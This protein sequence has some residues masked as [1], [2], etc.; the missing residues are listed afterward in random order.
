MKK[1]LAV[2]FFLGSAAD[3]LAQDTTRLSLLFLGDIMQHDSQISDAWDPTMKSY[4]YFPCFKQ[5]KPYT[6]AADLTI[7]NLELT[8]AGPPYKGYPQFSAPDE[9]LVALKD[10]GIDV[11]VTAN[12]HCVDRGKQGLERTVALLDSFNIPHTGTF[13]DDVSKLN[14]H[15]LLI[16]RNNFNLAILNYT[17]GTN[18]MPVTEPNIVN[19]IDTA[20]IRID[21]HKA[22][23][24]KQDVVIVFVHWG[25]EYQSLPSEWQEIV[26]DHCFKNGA[27]LVIGAHPHVIQPMEWDKNKNQLIAYSLG[28]FVSGQRKRYTDGGAMIN[29]ELEKVSYAS[30]SSKTRIDTANYI[31]QWVYRTEIG[32]N[33][34]MLPVQKFEKDTTFIADQESRD[35]FK[36]FVDDS[37]ALLSKHNKNI[38][39]SMIVPPD[40]LVT[41]KVLLDR[42]SE[43]GGVTIYPAFNVKFGAMKWNVEFEKVDEKNVHVY[44]G[45]FIRM[46][47]AMKLLTLLKADP[48][49]KNAQL[50]KFIDGKRVE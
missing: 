36:V 26:A 21:L 28:N 24:L 7:A 15:P 5:I 30:D 14:E 19:T 43:A 16:N 6:Q 23:S 8:L 47:E 44:V 22:K 49:F 11:M 1:F 12:N 45:N 10:M 48:Q 32:K 37:R 20:A 42:Q 29:V 25:S 27:D 46:D 35:A 33:Y 39:E 17:Y 3:S 13:V 31:L 9:L 34:Y 41:Y 4:N 18:G 50:A 40:T 2:L 38:V